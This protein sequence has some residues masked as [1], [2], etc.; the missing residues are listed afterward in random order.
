[1]GSRE[2]FTASEMIEAIK[3]SRGILAQAARRVGCNRQTVVN[4]IE[5]YPTVKIAFEEANETN[6][7]YVE[8]QLMKQIGAGQVAATIFFLKTKAGHRGYVERREVK[9]ENVSDMT[10]EELRRIAEGRHV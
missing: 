10:D 8:S 4:Y 9:V 3:E 7:D 2:K 5:K 6:I 1:M